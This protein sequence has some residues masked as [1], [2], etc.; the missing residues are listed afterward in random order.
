MKGTWVQKGGYLQEV[1]HRQRCA[2]NVDKCFEVA[3]VQSALIEGM[4]PV[5]VL[6]RIDRIQNDT[7]IQMLYLERDG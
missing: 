3:I 2:R 5:H 6:V 1:C 7:C 4:T